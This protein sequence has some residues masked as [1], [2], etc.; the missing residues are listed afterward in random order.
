MPLKNLTKLLAAAMAALFSACAPKSGQPPAVSVALAKDYTLADSLHFDHAI[1]DDLRKVTDAAFS[2]LASNPDVDDS[3]KPLQQEALQFPV[4]GKKAKELVLSVLADFRKKGYLIFW[5]EQHFGHDQDMIAVLKSTDQFDI[6]RFRATN[7]ANY[8]ITTDS[9]ISTLQHWYEQ[10]PFEIIG[11]DME[12]VEA[13]FTKLPEDV[14]AFAKE[15]YA[16]CPDIVDQGTG[17]LETLE[18]EIGRTRMLFLWWD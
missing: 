7:G 2:R 17:T 16:F 14:T 1:I 10:A 12:S 13:H 11:A 18:E 15:Q 3:T 5:S 8:Q 6:V 4:D 9:I